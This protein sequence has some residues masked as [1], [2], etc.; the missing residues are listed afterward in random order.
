[1]EPSKQ[2]QTPDSED[3]KATPGMPTDMPQASCSFGS[4]TGYENAF[5]PFSQIKT[6]PKP[7]KQISESAQVEWDYA[8]S[9][10]DK[11]KW[12]LKWTPWFSPQMIEGIVKY[13]YKNRLPAS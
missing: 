13:G 7:Y 5:H 12:H 8:A 10:S 4:Y 11:V 6:G 1:M 2:P 3:T 9:D